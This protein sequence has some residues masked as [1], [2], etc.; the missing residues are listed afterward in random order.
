MFKWHDTTYKSESIQKQTLTFSGLLF[1]YTIKFPLLKLRSTEFLCHTYF[2][3]H[4]L[5]KTMK[6]IST[7]QRSFFSWKI[8]LLRLIAMLTYSISPP[9][10]NFII[11][12]SITLLASFFPQKILKEISPEDKE[13]LLVLFLAPLQ[14]FSFQI[15][16]VWSLVYAL[17][18]PLQKRT[19]IQFRNYT[20]RSL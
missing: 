19:K 2:L 11:S 6:S 12:A 7:F 16:V 18:Q 13:A 1:N 20:V 9:K 10:C 4:Q 14:A 8:S 3:E 5:R 15:S 17:L